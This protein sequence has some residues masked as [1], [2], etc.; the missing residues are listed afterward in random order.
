M[1]IAII[2]INIG[3]YGVFWQEFFKSA[4][5]NLFPEAKK[6][7]YV[8]TDKI[9]EIKS[10]KDKVNTIYQEDM[11]WPNNTMKRFSLFLKIK[12][13]LLQYDYIFFA[14]A[15]AVFEAPLSVSVLNG[16]KKLLTVEHPGFHFKNK[17][18]KPFEQRKDSLAYVPLEKR[19]YYV[20]GAFYGGRA[21]Y[22]LE[23]TEEL[24]QKIEKDLSQGIIA[25]WH[26]E[27]FLNMYVE[28]HLKEV[29]ILSWHYLYFEEYY[30]PYKPIILL[31]NKRKYLSMSNGRYKNQHSPFI[32]IKTML[33][34]IKWRLY[35]LFGRYPQCKQRDRDGKY[36]DTD[37]SN[38]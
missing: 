14:N 31:R 34:N 28:Q 15:N 12:E 7:Y 26:D 35:V 24:N 36:L 9:D 25:I 5:I 18:D 16:K 11:G 17:K 29:Q 6:N 3:E 2:S 23:M 19:K 1:K 4:E 38:F 30:F 33:R 22:F 21:D 8:F 37:I 27:S 10:L 20:Q 32:G 13:A